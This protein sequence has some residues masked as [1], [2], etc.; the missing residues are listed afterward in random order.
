MPCSSAS[1]G[2]HSSQSFLQEHS[3][4]LLIQ[5]CTIVTSHGISNGTERLRREKKRG[6]VTDA[7]ND[8]KQV[9]E[10]RNRL[11]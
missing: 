6:D 10:D 9:D 7:S 3:S 4:L 1:I 2:V 8:P 11:A 5:Y